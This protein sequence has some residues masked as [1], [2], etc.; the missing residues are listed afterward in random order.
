MGVLLNVN[1]PC[2]IFKLDNLFPLWANNTLQFSETIP[3]VPD[4]DIRCI[5]FH[6]ICFLTLQGRTRWTRTMATERSA[7]HP[8]FRDSIC[9]FFSPSANTTPSQGRPELSLT[10]VPAR[11]GY[12]YSDYADVDEDADIG[13]LNMPYQVR[14]PNRPRLALGAL[15]PST[16]APSTRRARTVDTLNAALPSRC[17]DFRLRQH[18]RVDAGCDSPRR[19]SRARRARARSRELVGF[20]HSS[21][22]GGGLFG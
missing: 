4:Q 18:H 21:A 8:A 16:H 17:A 2:L 19:L 9:I 3:K 10:S 5:S 20:G 15:A 22:Q 1:G 13:V 14:T 11:Q 12:Y 7:N 6:F